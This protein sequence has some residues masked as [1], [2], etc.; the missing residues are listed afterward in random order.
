VGEY[1][2]AEYVLNGFS[3]EAEV[4][5]DIGLAAIDKLLDLLDV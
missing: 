5:L 4:D 1:T 3:V 2:K